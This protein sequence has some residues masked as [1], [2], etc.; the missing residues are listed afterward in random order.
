MKWKA[1]ILCNPLEK[2]YD[3]VS[4]TFKLVDNLMN[5]T[6]LVNTSLFMI[7]LVHQL[8]KIVLM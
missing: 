2:G 5:Y 3:S 6:L 7:V 8:T 4:F 1:N